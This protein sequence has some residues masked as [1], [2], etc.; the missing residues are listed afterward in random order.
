MKVALSGDPNL[1]GPKSVPNEDHV[2]NAEEAQG[3][4][5]SQLLL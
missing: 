5:Y 3:D 2:S 1:C 4:E